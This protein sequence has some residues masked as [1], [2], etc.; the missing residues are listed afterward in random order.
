M[1]L[2]DILTMMDDISGHTVTPVTDPSLLRDDEPRSI[3][4]SPSRLE[5]LIG[6]LPN[7]EFRETLA[8]MYDA[9]RKES[10]AIQ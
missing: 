4:G 7:P 6:P 8:R 3:V 9:F 10:G 1:H 5:A 2:A